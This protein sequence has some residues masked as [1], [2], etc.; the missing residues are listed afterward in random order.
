MYSVHRLTRMP[1]SGHW[2]NSCRS[3]SRSSRWCS[4]PR[5]TRSITMI[6]SDADSNMRRFGP[7]AVI[8]CVALIAAAQAQAQQQPAYP[9]PAQSYPSAPPA[10]PNPGYPT[11][12]PTYPNPANP[13]PAY[14]NPAYPQ[15]PCYPN[16]A[17]PGGI[18]QD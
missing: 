13:N 12:N 1:S 16:P 11:P 17:Y 5:E 15:Q 8:V 10:Y 18:P 3:G 9:A 6:D 7:L 4:A 14:P 2:A